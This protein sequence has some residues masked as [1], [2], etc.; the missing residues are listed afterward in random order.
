MNALIA[1]VNGEYPTFVFG[2][3]AYGDTYVE[4][5][6]TQLKRWKKTMKDYA[7]VQKEMGDAV[8]HYSPTAIKRK[9]S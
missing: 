3:N 4:V 6:S 5:S 1:I 7:T 2:K 9:K 8:S